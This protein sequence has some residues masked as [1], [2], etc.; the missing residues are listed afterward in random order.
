MADRITRLSL[1]LFAQTVTAVFMPGQMATPITPCSSPAW[2]AFNQNPD[3]GTQTLCN[4]YSTTTNQEAIIALFRIVNRHVGNLPPGRAC[5][6][7]RLSGSGG[8]QV[9]RRSRGTVWRC[10]TA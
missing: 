3:D 2:R 4:L 7:S 10:D 8:A 5:F 1:L 6:L 9:R